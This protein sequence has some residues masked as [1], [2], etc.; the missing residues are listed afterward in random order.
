MD[1]YNKI[2]VELG[3][4]RYMIHVGQNLFQLLP[5]L[6][7]TGPANSQIA[8]ISVPPVSTLYLEKVRSAFDNSWQVYQL[9]IPDG[10]GS[11][12]TI[13]LQEIYT[14]L[15]QNRLERNCTILS[16]GG[17]VVGDLAGYAAAT[18]LRGVN[19][20]HIPTSLLAQVDSSIGG[21]VGI[22]HRL[23]KNLIGSFYQP[24][25]VVTDIT[26]IGTLAQEEFLC[27]VG[28]VIKYAVLN[29]NLFEY[30]EK[31]LNRLLIR[32]QS[33]LLQV[34]ERCIKI[35]ARI[36]GADEKEQGIRANLNLG[37]TFGHAL[38]KYYKFKILKH[39]QA[40][41]LGLYC[42]LHISQVLKQ[43]KPDMVERIKNLLAQIPV[44][45][46]AGGKN[47]SPAKIVPLM[48]T[49]KKIRDGKI[50]LIL[51]QEI[52]RVIKYPLSDLKILLQSLESLKSL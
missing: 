18:Y 24:R 19:L 13:V 48:Q 41:L 5:H 4:N 35:K 34:I 46:P 1:A 42:T 47:F 17:G 50:N 21:K 22:N 10:E 2:N 14:W 11:K 6:V 7:R 38:E 36:V 52:G 12:S 33:T 31:N 51:I 8:I 23:G 28:E 40:V 45:L 43:I 3:S 16:L 9:D 37:H 39:G 44:T 15:I 49:D 32:D 30:L 27:G 26:V 20:I 25:A 29:K